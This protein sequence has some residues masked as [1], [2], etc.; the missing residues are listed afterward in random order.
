MHI[1]HISIWT[2][3]LEAQKN[4]YETYFSAREG[5]KYTN[6]ETHFESYF[7]SFATGARLEIM[8]APDVKTAQNNTRTAG[9]AHFAMAVGSRDQVDRLTERLEA[10]GYRIVSHPRITGDGYYE[11]V[12]LDPDGN[13][14]EI[15]V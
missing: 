10:D 13:R 14:V 9:F 6:P 7:L 11:S 4:F 5:K 15:T 3:Q 1:E 12:I 8:Q 2:R